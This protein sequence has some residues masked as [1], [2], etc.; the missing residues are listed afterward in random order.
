MM[1]YT[2]LQVLKNVILLEVL[3]NRRNNVVC[4]QEMRDRK[5]MEDA[6]KIA[7]DKVCK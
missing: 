1:S 4:F 5:C 6:A 3:F 2:I 7:I